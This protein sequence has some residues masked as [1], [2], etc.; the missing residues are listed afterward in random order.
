[1]I[2]AVGGTAL[3]ISLGL[4]RQRRDDQH[5]GQHARSANWPFKVDQA[6]VINLPRS[7][8]LLMGFFG[9]LFPALVGGGARVKAVGSVCAKLG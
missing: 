6:T 4:S 9:G 1:L 2:S 7:R 3:G 5:L 8:R